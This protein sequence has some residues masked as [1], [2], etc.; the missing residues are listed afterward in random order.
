M[1]NIVLFLS[2]IVCC[3]VLGYLFKIEYD[4][5]H[6]EFT[7]YDMYETELKFFLNGFFLSIIVIV[8]GCLTMAY[9]WIFDQ[10]FTKYI[11][12]FGVPLW[13]IV[14]VCLLL[15]LAAKVIAKK[16]N[17][18]L[19]YGLAILTSTINYLCI[20]LFVVILHLDLVKV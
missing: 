10:S 13:L 11:A 4:D 8:A 16:S 7:F 2:I 19:L 20:T 9:S 18:K 17:T 6:S 1:Q 3:F 15:N 5:R 14:S 12:Y